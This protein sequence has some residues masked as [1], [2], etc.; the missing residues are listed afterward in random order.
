MII[1]ERYEDEEYSDNKDYSVSVSLG[2]AVECYDLR[3]WISDRVQSGF[4]VEVYDYEDGEYRYYA[5]PD[6]AE[7]VDITN[8]DELEIDRN[9]D[10]FYLG[11]ALI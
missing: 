11:G 7:D 1:K 8:V 4:F 5:W 10:F 3:D 9:G 2:E 6:N